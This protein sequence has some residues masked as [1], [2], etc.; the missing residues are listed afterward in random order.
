MGNNNRLESFKENLDTVIIGSGI[1]GLTAALCLARA[2]QKVLIVEQHKLPGGWC[3]SFKLSGFRFSPGLHYVGGLNKGGSLYRLYK[4]LGLANDLVFYR[5]KPSAYEHALVDGMQFDFPNDFDALVDTLSKRFPHEKEGIRRYLALVKTIGREI[6]I[7]SRLNSFSEKLVNLWKVRHLVLYHASTVKS[8]CDK[9]I[10]DPVL[11]KVIN[12]QYGDHG[13][14]SG[15]ASFLIHCGVMDH[16]FHG[17]FYPEGGAGALVKATLRKI[18]KY[19]GEIITG[20]RVKRILLDEKEKNKAIGVELAGGEKI[21]AKRVVSNADPEKTFGDMVGL[22]RTS[23][24]LQKKLEQTTYSVSSL[25]LFLAVDMDVQKAGLDTGNIWV[26]N[27][28]DKDDDQ[29]F[30]SLLEEDY[31]S[32]TAFPQLFVSCTTLKDPAHYDGKHHTLEVIA[33]ADYERFKEF[34]HKRDSKA[35]LDLKERITNKFIASL[36]KIVPGI[37]DNIVMK[38][39]ATPL[40]NEFYVNSTRGNVYGTAKNIRQVGLGAYGLH[41][42][43]KNLYLCGA[44]TTA[45]GISGASYS[46]LETAAKILKCK[47]TDLLHDNPEQKINIVDPK[48]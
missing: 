7:F 22:T 19:G 37:G 27:G 17:G 41:T 1:G 15:E 38:E 13:L 29:L 42:E 23:Q 21:F 11:K 14:P 33:F 48:G 35:Y 12:I 28:A 31:S 40:S 20:E 36:E 6:Q 3:Q 4:G 45:H 44:S 16:Y 30:N 47:G 25:I 8:V 18:K 39:L 24:K 26:M 32:E 5:M 46:G 9:F 43:I 2:G 10:K 34:E